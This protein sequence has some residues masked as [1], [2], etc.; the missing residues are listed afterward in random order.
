VGRHQAITADFSGNGSDRV[1]VFMLIGRSRV[2]LAA[3]L[4]LAGCIAAGAPAKKIESLS[5]EARRAVLE[6][7]IYDEVELTGKEHAVIDSVTGT[8]CRYRSRDSA[9]TETDALNEAKYWATNRGAE[10]LKNIKCD[11]PRGKTLFNRCWESITC[12]GQAIKFAK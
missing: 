7:P 6:L 8:S 4:L 3:V 9:A 11:P 1:G 10:G 12:T 2:L 5:P